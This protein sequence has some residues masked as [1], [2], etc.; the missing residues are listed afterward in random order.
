[1]AAKLTCPCNT[2]QTSNSFAISATGLGIDSKPHLGR[3]CKT[4]LV[5]APLAVCVLAGCSAFFHFT[6]WLSINTIIFYM[7]NFFLYILDIYNKNIISK[8]Q[9][10]E[11]SWNHEYLEYYAK[12]TCSLNNR[13]SQP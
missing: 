1:M 12:L 11:G 8:F 2:L 9:F 7:Q 3:T 6:V 10:L 5:F 4:S 13:I